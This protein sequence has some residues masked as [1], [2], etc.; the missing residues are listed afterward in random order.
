MAASVEDRP[1][2]P[3]GFVV[4]LSKYKGSPEGVE[5]GEIPE[6]MR[7]SF[8][9]WDGRRFEQGD[10]KVLPLTEALMVDES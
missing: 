5:K 2:V 10:V 7:R 6:G 4:V 9:K 3:Q 8:R 1:S